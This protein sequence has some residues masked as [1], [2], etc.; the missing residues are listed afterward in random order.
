MSRILQQMER[1]ETTV[2]L[3]GAAGDAWSLMAQIATDRIA[4]SSGP[5]PIRAAQDHLRERL[6]EPIGVP[7]LARMAGLSTSHFAAPFRRATGG[8]VTA[9]LKSLR[10]ARARE[11]LDTTDRPSERSSG[12]SATPTRSISPDTFAA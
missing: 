7:E 5:E 1:D 11:L 6:A 4:G 10:M 2:T 9:Y 12:S 8:G 3:I